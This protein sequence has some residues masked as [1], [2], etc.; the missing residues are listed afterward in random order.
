MAAIS[1][2]TVI[3]MNNESLAERHYTPAEIAQVWQV[4]EATIRRLFADMPGVL[5]LSFSRPR[6]GR[7][8]YCT[9]RIPASL[10]ARVHAERSK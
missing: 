2:S 4:S 10:A 3:K 1:I 5:K 7:R 8:A 9:L 6:S